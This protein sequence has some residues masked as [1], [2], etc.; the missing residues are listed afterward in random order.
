MTEAQFKD[1]IGRGCAKVNIST[2]LK[3]TYMKANLEF[4]RGAEARDKWDPPS[5]FV[6]VRAACVAMATGYIH[7]FGSAGKAW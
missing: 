1:L 6:D 7:Q 3:V 5:L 2:A 4:L